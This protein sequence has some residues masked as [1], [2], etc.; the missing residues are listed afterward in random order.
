MK[1]KIGLVSAITIILL[2]AAGLWLWFYKDSGEKVEQVPVPEQ[3]QTP[4]KHKENDKKTE[5]VN[6]PV[7]PPKSQMRLA[8][9]PIHFSSSNPTKPEDHSMSLKKKNR[10]IDIAPNV[11]VRPGEGVVIKGA[12]SSES[13]KI[14]RD[15]EYQKDYQVLYEKRY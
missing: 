12:D 5:T 2:L 4:V 15:K 14:K 13:I 7:Q 10:D 8:P 6:P 3:R 11:V 9:E 1:R